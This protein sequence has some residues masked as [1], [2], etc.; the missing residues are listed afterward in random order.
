MQQSEEKQLGH[1]RWISPMAT[2]GHMHNLTDKPE[3]VVIYNWV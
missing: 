3:Q 1:S 2:A